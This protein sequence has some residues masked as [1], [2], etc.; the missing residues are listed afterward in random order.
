M[1]DKPPYECLLVSPS[2][3]TAINRTAFLGDK[4]SLSLLFKLTVPFPI[5]RPAPFR[6]RN[7]SSLERRPDPEVANSL[8]RAYLGSDVA[9]DA[10]LMEGEAERLV[11]SRRPP[12][13]ML[14]L[15]SWSDFLR[16]ERSGVATRV[17]E[18]AV[19]DSRG[20]GERGSGDTTGRNRA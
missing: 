7:L 3:T 19:W 11:E 5:G 14:L 6:P 12:D 9:L 20:L 16:D 8:L 4:R 10:V 17:D 13:L 18:E 15:F 2:S 1:R